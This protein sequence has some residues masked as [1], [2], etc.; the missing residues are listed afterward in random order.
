MADTRKTLLE[1]QL[2]KAEQEKAAR[3]EA[4]NKYMDT[5][6]V[7]PDNWLA[8]LG[9]RDAQH[10]ILKHPTSQDVSSWDTPLNVLGTT[11]DD[12]SW[13]S[14]PQRKADAFAR[15][16]KQR[17]EF[18]EHDPEGLRVKTENETGFDYSKPE[19]MGKKISLGPEAIGSDD[20]TPEHEF[21]HRGQMVAQ[22]GIGESDP[23]EYPA[24]RGVGIHKGGDVGSTY[25]EIFR[26]KPSEASKN[27]LARDQEKAKAE[28]NKRYTSGPMGG[29][30]DESFQPKEETSKTAKIINLLKTLIQ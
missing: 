5:Y 8:K 20:F 1:K 23:Y 26:E 24:I 18:N 30:P 13:I 28:Y 22:T 21:M 7:N 2:T 29:M 3:L 9:Q 27:I 25:E 14:D 4:T 16:K 11:Q 15:A 6:K 19:T 17:T 10:F 12:L